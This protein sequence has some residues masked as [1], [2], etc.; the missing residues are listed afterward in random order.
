M[1]KDQITAKIVSR[2]A[3]RRSD[4]E[5]LESRQRA[6]RL[7]Q[8][9]LLQTSRQ[10]HLAAQPA[11]DVTEGSVAVYNR[12]KPRD[13]VDSMYCTTLVAL[14]NAVMASFTEA[15]T[16]RERNEHL[17]RAYEGIALLTDLVAVREDRRALIT[18]TERRNEVLDQV[19][20]RYLT[21]PPAD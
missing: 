3:D 14:Q 6:G 2:R 15:T 18:D 7:V 5:R 4:T 21:D 9:H 12:L 8:L 1:R 13:P 20:R 11:A 17:A 10:P 19:M 16:S